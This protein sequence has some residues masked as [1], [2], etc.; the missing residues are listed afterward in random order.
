LGAARWRFGSV[1]GR[2]GGASGGGSLAGAGAV[3]PGLVTFWVADSLCAAQGAC[4]CSLDEVETGAAAR[5][6]CPATDAGLV[7]SNWSSTR[8]EAATGI[9]GHRQA[10]GSPL[11]RAAADAA[12][13]DAAE[14]PC[15]AD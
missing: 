11:P 2:I 5:S 13:A 4:L 8:C 7:W 10:R 15:K 6:G 1:L 12:D 9:R 14:V 3:C